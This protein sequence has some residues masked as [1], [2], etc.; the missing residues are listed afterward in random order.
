MNLH[1]SIR[2]AAAVGLLLSVVGAGTPAWADAG[3][4]TRAVT[5][6]GV[7]RGWRAGTADRPTITAPRPVAPGELNE[8]P[9]VAVDADGT[10]W[11]V[12]VGLVSGVEHVFLRPYR[13]EVPG[14]RLDVG[15][16]QGLQFSPRVIA[17]GRDVWVAWSYKAGD[18]PGARWKVVTRV[19]RSGVPGEFAV[20][21]GLTEDALRPALGLDANGHPWVAWE[22]RTGARFRVVARPLGGTDGPGAVQVV[23]DGGELNLRPAI[24]PAPEGGIHVTWDQ[25]ADGE[26]H[27]LLRRVSRHGRGP[28]IRVSTEQ[29]F[30]IGPSATVDEEGNV[31]VAYA[32]NAD[33]EGRQRV[34][35]SLR[36]RVVRNGRVMELAGGQP[37]RVATAPGRL[38]AVEFPTIHLDP[39]GRLWVF[40]RRGQGFL[41]FRYEG[42][43][44][45]PPRDLSRRGWGGRGKDMRAAWSPQGFHLVARRLHML[46]HQLLIPPQA[47]VPPI[48]FA[49]Q[50]MRTAMA[51]D[52]PEDQPVVTLPDGRPTVSFSDSIP[53]IVVASIHLSDTFLWSL[54][55]AYVQMTAG[56]SWILPGHP[57]MGQ[58]VAFLD[59]SEAPVVSF[60]P[61]RSDAGPSATALL[62]STHFRSPPLVLP[63]GVGPPRAPLP[64]SVYD[65]DEDLENVALPTERASGFYFGDLHTHSWMSDGAGDPDE[66]YTRSRDRYRFD[67]V[68]LTDHGNENGNL[69]LPSEWAYLELMAD[70]FYRPGKF[71]TFV[72]YEWTSNVYPR[73]AGHRNVYYPGTRGQLLD[74][75]YGAEST[76]TLFEL[77]KS[78]RAIAVPHHIG[79]T[80]TDW[81]NHDPDV[82]RL[83]EIVSVHGAFEKPGNRP[84]RPRHEM[85][86]MFIRDGL[87]RGLRFGLVGGSDGHG[88]PWHYGVS[89]KEDIWRTGLTGIVAPALTRLSLFDALHNRLTVA[90]SGAPISIW[91]TVDGAP[92]GSELVLDHPPRFDIRVEGSA[93][94]EELA[95]IRDGEDVMRLSGHGKVLSR[96][97]VDRPPPGQHY[98]Y[99]RVIQADNEVAWASPIWV[100]MKGRILIGPPDP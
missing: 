66:V 47:P 68:A 19:I 96:R 9:D 31:Y 36:V 76:T 41:V 5:G 37:P 60:G 15:R 88:Y 27:V 12:W 40:S 45:F 74:A 95:L 18:G 73:G 100:E 59:S 7:E 26:Y 77:L 89:R 43:R 11:V 13:G 71:V 72:S 25:Y 3:V 50:D 98:Y 67:F 97:V 90:T 64:S 58:R 34:G 78:Q 70:F 17:A 57:N 81:E 23:S 30:N 80:G 94:I 75:V 69:L 24:V 4:A 92:M 83:V 22:S 62:E 54:E 86:G 46:A 42:D 79:W 6:V 39:A 16:D 29:A 21:S 38:D 56:T 8:Y 28:V 53:A 33:P 20:V 99:L 55:Q 51:P 84:I 87:S 2:S 65:Y 52:D 10:A 49:D 91:M 14:K 61:I 93:P 32:S 82:Q 85:A 48:S 1:R 44:W 63:D 35:K